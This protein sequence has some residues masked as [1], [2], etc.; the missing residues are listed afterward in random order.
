[1]AYVA[2]SEGGVAAERHEIERSIARLKSI[3]NLRSIGL[4]IVAVSA[5]VAAISAPIVFPVVAG[6]VTAA[7][8]VGEF[9]S[10]RERAQL[11]AHLRDL[12]ERRAFSAKEVEEYSN[13]ANYFTVAGSAN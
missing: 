5:V 7:T 4:P 13:A 3:N 12:A 10:R 9:A 2:K 6:L 1:V 11:D 8:I